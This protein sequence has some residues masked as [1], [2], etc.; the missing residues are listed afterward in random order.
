MKV[1]ILDD[2]G[3][4]WVMSSWMVS[5]HKPFF[6]QVVCACSSVEFICNLVS[7]CPEIMR[8]FYK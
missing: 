4:T 2:T 8:E 6:L 7:Y 3:S 5:M 1:L